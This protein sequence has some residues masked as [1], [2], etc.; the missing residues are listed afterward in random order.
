MSLHGFQIV[1]SS[2]TLKQPY[3]HE[4]CSAFHEKE[5]RFVELN[6]IYE[7]VMTRPAYDA[8][9]DAWKAYSRDRGQFEPWNSDLPAPNASL[10]IQ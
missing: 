7:Q 1:Y 10:M 2:T 9:F 4:L 5:A 6:G 8:A 3:Y